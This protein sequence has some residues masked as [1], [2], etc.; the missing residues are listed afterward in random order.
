MLLLLFCSGALPVLF[1]VSFGPCVPLCTL[2]FSHLGGCFLFLFLNSG[3]I[4]FFTLA[5]NVEP[6]NLFVG[7][8]PFSPWRF[9]VFGQLI[10]A[11]WTY[12]FKT[13]QSETTRDCKH[14]GSRNEKAFPERALCNY[15]GNHWKGSDLQTLS[16]NLTWGLGVLR[17]PIIPLISCCFFFRPEIVKRFE[18]RDRTDLIHL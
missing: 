12:H 8:N 16:L 14:T 15:H 3:T 9:D 1:S 7:P 11:L 2:I 5:F 4:F 13:I 17:R 6:N 10:S 18:C